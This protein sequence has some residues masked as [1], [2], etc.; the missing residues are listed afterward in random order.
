MS[1]PQPIVI[2]GSDS[3]PE[4]DTIARLPTTSEV[5]HGTIVEPES[6]P[7][8][9]SLAMRKD[10]IWATAADLLHQ[11]SRHMPQQPMNI[12]HQL[13]MVLRLAP[14]STS[15]AK[16]GGAINKIIQSPGCIAVSSAASGGQPDNLG[17]AEQPIVDPYN[18]E[19]TLQ[20]WQENK[21]QSSTILH[22]H[23]LF[24]DQSPTCHKC[25]TVN[26]ISF[27]PNQS[28][29]MASAGNDCSVQLWLDDKKLVNGYY[30][31]PKAPYD[32]VYQEKD[33]LLAVTCANG[34]VYVHSTQSGLPFGDP[35]DLH[36]TPLDVQQSVGSVVWGHGASA[37]LLF[38][39]SEAQR[40]DDY[41]GFHVA[42]DPDQRRCA[43]DFSVR[44]SGD[45]MALDPDGERLAICTVGPRQV[46]DVRRR[47]GQEPIQHIRL[48]TFD[49]GSPE[50]GSHANEDQVTTASFSPDGILLAVARSDDELHLYDSRFMG[51]NKWG[52]VDAVWV[53][54][55]CGRGFGII[56][57]GA[58]GCVR[59]WDPRR[60]AED[61]QNGEV[62]ARPNVDVGHFSV[63]DPHNG[64]KPLVVGDNGGRVYV[65]DYAASSVF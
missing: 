19:G 24:E 36:V 65:Y 3:E 54:G 37:D 6:I 48:D 27:D 1:Q 33:S 29:I 34:S 49:S 14:I 26:S 43:Y 9:S 40:A 64:E 39:S 32:V 46:Y 30:K 56:T 18:H 7:P 2:H 31:Y 60:S 44:E 57:G 20:I 52:I 17:A 47:N 59:F 15:F 5:V 61:V 4:H 62:L 41:H 13:P 58:D 22:G 16:A 10:F 53:N 63:G 42:F 55:W 51:R 35:I 28:Q 11:N 45:A 50:P 38:A 12:V 21:G 23:C 25:Y 8:P